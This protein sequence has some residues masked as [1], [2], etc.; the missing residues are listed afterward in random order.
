MT[1]FSTSDA[2]DTTFV[3]PRYA[4]ARIRPKY[5]LA[6]NASERAHSS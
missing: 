4:R 5:K 2:S 1:M 6:S 3:Y